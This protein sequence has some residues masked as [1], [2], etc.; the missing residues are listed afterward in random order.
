MNRQHKSIHTKIIIGLAAG[1]ALGVICKWLLPAH[2][3]D[4]IVSHIAR[5]A[6]QIF[7]KLL[8]CAVVP[9]AV[10]AITLG[11]ANM[12]STERIGRVAAKVLA[13]TVLF[14]GTAVFIGILGVNIT[15]PGRGVSAE[16]RQAMLA[17]LQSGD[18]MAEIKA[19]TPQHQPL[20][21]SV[22]GLLPKNPF[23]DAANAYNGGLIPLLIFSIILG[24]AMNS[25]APEKAAPLKHL[26]ESVFELM[27]RIIGFAMKI[28]PYGI[29]G[30][31]FSATAG[32]GISAIAMLFKY[33]LLVLV[34]LCVHMFGFYSL[35][36]RLISKHKPLDF[37]R[38]CQ[39]V[40]ATAFATSSS[41]AT[42]PVALKTATENLKIP[43]QIAQFVVTLGATTNHNGTALYEGITV[44]FLAQLFG[45]D[46]SISQQIFVVG[47]CVMA[48]IGTAG[49]PGG[50]LPFLVVVLQYI[51]VPLEGIGIIMGLDR[52]LDMCRTVINVVGDL[53]VAVCIADTEKRL[54][55]ATAIS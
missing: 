18:V 48:S 36:L 34:C 11:I 35:M 43:P 14:S 9:L 41:S 28:A 32:A 21:D 45:V 26:L 49:V 6:G 8:F 12:G 19:A 38:A 29:A 4:W 55:A 37:F 30:L 3:L 52:L 47:M 40:M 31:L 1:I 24:L 33:V 2:E 15:G 53:A 46:L 51:G 42:L 10:A 16:Q 50:S 22:V 39:N 20:I 44:L 13:L 23:S 54:P 17:N 7:L 27:T 25:V 5:P